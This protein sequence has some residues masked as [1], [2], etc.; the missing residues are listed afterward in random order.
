MNRKFIILFAFLLLVAVVFSQAKVDTV[1]NYD[2]NGK[3]NGYWEKT[4]RGGVLV[5]KGTFNHGAPVGKFYY[6]YPDQKVRAIMDHYQIG[7]RDSAYV[8]TYY[9]DGEVMAVGVYMDKRKE[10]KWQYFNKDKD[11]LMTENYHNGRKEGMAYTYQKDGTYAEVQYWKFGYEDSTWTSY[12]ENGN[13]VMERNYVRGKLD[14]KIVTY[15]DSGVKKM[16]GFY[17]RDERTGKF[18]YYDEDGN[19]IEEK[20]Y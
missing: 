7:G 16:E 11:L 17:K 12:N 1:N 5:Y 10:G 14:G 2:N 8:T 9:H 18:I 15:Y 19:V 13:I 4:D 6:F 3:K 20:K